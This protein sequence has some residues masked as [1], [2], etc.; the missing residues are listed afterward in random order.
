MQEI[1]LN[2]HNEAESHK[3]ENCIQLKKISIFTQKKT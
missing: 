1:M 2:A 3:N